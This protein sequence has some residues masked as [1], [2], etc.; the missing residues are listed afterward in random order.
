MLDGVTTTGMVS[1]PAHS[2]I[3][4]TYAL[5]TRGI[6]EFA[7]TLEESTVE[8]QKARLTALFYEVEFTCL[9]KNW[10]DHLTN[11]GIEKEDAYKWVAEIGHVVDA[12]GTSL[13]DLIDLFKEDNVDNIAVGLETWIW[14]T[15]EMTMWTI[16]D[17]MRALKGT[18]EKYLPPE[19]EDED[20]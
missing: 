3:S 6:S 7:L 20:E 8:D 2:R 4:Q 19:P 1:M 18:Y 16:D 13:H 11:L 15:R 10:V 14:K 9:K 5:M 17:A 12:Y